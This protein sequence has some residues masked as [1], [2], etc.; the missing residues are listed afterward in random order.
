[1]FAER[2]SKKCY[3]EE[4]IVAVGINTYFY[5]LLPLVTKNEENQANYHH[6]AGL[7]AKQHTPSK[8]GSFIY[9]DLRHTTLPFF[10]FGRNRIFVVFLFLSLFPLYF[11]YFK[12]TM[13]MQFSNVPL[14]HA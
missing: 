11:L 10:L 12:Q 4:T 7:Q 14:T 2:V 6:H 1:M 9:L 13:Q 8:A 3:F 5:A